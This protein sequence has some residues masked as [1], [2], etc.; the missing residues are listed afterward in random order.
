[1]GRPQPFLTSPCREWFIMSHRVKKGD[2]PEIVALTT[3]L[4]PALVE[5]APPLASGVVGGRSATA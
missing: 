4:E 2:V 5:N 3:W 1:M